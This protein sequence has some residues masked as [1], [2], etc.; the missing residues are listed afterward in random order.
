MVVL[1]DEA[2]QFA[3]SL[4]LGQLIVPLSLHA[5]KNIGLQE[6]QVGLLL[7]ISG[8]GIVLTQHAISRSLTRR[9]IVTAAVSG[10]LILAAGYLGVSVARG[11]AGLLAAVLIIT[12][13]E[14]VASPSM[15]VLAIEIAPE[16]AKGRYLGLSGFAESAGM[17]AAPVI[18]G[19]LLDCFDGRWLGAPWLAITA[20][21][22]LAAWG[23][24]AVGRRHH[25]A[26]ALS[27]RE[28]LAILEAPLH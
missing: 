17:A 3:V 19:L 16:R 14:A 27:L 10:S 5:T 22:L 23:L 7:S 24:A 18:G 4:V 8:L 28:R 1:A 2:D 15:Q 11:F 9:S 26:G 13:G 21:A 25:A 20:L 6:A 12:L